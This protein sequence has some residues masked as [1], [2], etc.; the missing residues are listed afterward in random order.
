MDDE[1]REALELTKADL[2]SMLEGGEPAKLS[3]RPP[4]ALATTVIVHSSQPEV[5]ALLNGVNAGQKREVIAREQRLV[6]A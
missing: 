2:V 3:R 6:S 5:E 4:P 1:T